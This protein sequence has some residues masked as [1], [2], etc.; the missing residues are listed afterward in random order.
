MT[1]LKAALWDIIIVLSKAVLEDKLQKNSLS[2]E[3]IQY[4]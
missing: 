1:S 4:L 3:A 2:K